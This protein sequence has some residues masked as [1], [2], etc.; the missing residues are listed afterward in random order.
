VLAHPDA[1]RYA[2]GLALL[3]VAVTLLVAFPGRSIEAQTQSETQV[4]DDQQIEFAR[5]V[6]QRTSLSP[7]Q[8]PVA[9]NP[10]DQPGAIQLSPTGALKPWEKVAVELPNR[11][12][13][14]DNGAR[15]DAGVVAVGNRLFVIGGS[16]V[17]AGTLDTVFS[18]SV[19]QVVGNIE[20]HGVPETSPR[21]ADPFWLNDPLPATLLILDDAGCDSVLQPPSSAR[22]RVAAAALTTGVNTG[23]FYVVGGLAAEDICGIELTSPVVQIGAVDAAGA[24]TWSEGPPLPSAPDPDRPVEGRRRGVENATATVVRASSGK[25]FL[26]VIGGLSTYD[27]LDPTSTVEKS[28]FY[29]EIN[30]ATGALG[31]WT[32]GA[33]V[34]VIDPSP[35][36][37]RVGLHN[38][39]ATHITTLVN[40]DA[41]SSVVDGLVVAGGFTNVPRTE[42]NDFVYRATVD[43][44]T[45]A[46]TWDDTP[47]APPGTSRVTLVAGGHSGLSA[48]AYNNKLYMI[49]GTPLGQPPVDWV[50]TATFNDALEIRNIPNDAAFFIGQNNTVLPDGPRTDTGAALIDALPPPD[51]PSQAL[52]SAWAYVVG[53]ADATG[54]ASRFIFRGRIGGD[55][56][57]D[58]LRAPE[59]WFYSNVFDV[60]FEQPGQTR[61]NARVLAIRWATQIDRG[62]NG[63]ADIIVQFRK[64]L[65]SDPNCPNESVFTAADQWYTLD[66]DTTSAF[67]SQSGTAERPYNEVSLRDAF[68]TEDFV[69]TCFQY[70]ARFLQNGETGGQPNAPAAAGATPKLYS[71]NIEKIVAGNPDLRV[72]EF[73]Q[74]T[75]LNGRLANISASIQNLSLEGIDNTVTPTVASQTG[76]GGFFVGMCVARSDPGQPPPTLTPPDPAT[77]NLGQIPPCV[78]AIYELYTYQLPPGAV[79]PLESRTI[80]GT[81]PQGWFRANPDFTRTYY[82]DLKSLFCAPGNYAVALLVDMGN[83]VSEGDAGETNNL[84]QDINGNQPIVHSFTTNG[85]TNLIA[86]P[87]VRN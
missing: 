68:G 44:A 82:D 21:Y 27:T 62:Q 65:R 87:L 19:N 4:L 32:R 34:P 16:G 81:E 58:N 36:D 23:F 1:R 64:V 71:M 5:G 11:P 67:Y 50:Q 20:E 38:H 77:V 56:A 47:S 13:Q 9:T 37:G 80:N 53:G 57:L 22:T 28:V 85:C 48:L 84:G 86:L 26:Y 31:A 75:V 18:A 79:V 61:K 74:P 33:D 83:L 66:A 41:G 35:S 42:I 7:E 76:E 10:A 45:G 2:R 15:A 52:G 51:N 3:T 12:A 24:V 8:N 6:F 39:A 59:G 60:T 73:A 46:L 29:A 40:T 49:G 63:G 70:R 54:T 17:G 14:G 43:P 78:Q 69:A 30:T 25:A 55:E 72:K